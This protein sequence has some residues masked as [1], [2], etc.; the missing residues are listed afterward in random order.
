[1]P[2]DGFFRQRLA[3]QQ[4]K[5]ESKESLDAGSSIHNTSR[6]VV[7]LWMGRGHHGETDISSLVAMRV[8]R[9]V[10][11]RP[12][13]ELSSDGIFANPAI[14]AVRNSACTDVGSEVLH[15]DDLPLAAGRQLGT[16]N[17]AECLASTI[18]TVKAPFSVVAVRSVVSHSFAGLIHVA[19]ISYC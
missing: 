7:I 15:M 11:T 14:L 19:E 4:R 12:H 3:T 10:G 5:T 8:A 6:V 13:S 9:L 18:S 16:H 1:L 17:V 2:E